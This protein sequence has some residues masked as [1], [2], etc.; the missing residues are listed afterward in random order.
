MKRAW[1]RPTPCLVVVPRDQPDLLDLLS[2]ELFADPEIEVVLDRREG[3][4]R[5]GRAGTRPDER[6]REDR[7]RSIDEGEILGLDGVVIAFRAEAREAA[8]P[9]LPPAEAGVPVAVPV[10]DEARARITNWL[11]ESQGVL[12]TVPTV[13]AR[14]RA[15]LKVARALERR[16]A[17]LATE[18]RT[19]RRE[20]QRL[21]ADRATLL[22][23][24]ERALPRPGGS[25]GEQETRIAVETWREATAEVTA[26]IAA[27]RERSEWL[28]GEIREAKHALG[29]P[30]PVRA[31]VCPRCASVIAGPG[32]DARWACVVCAWVGPTPVEPTPPP[33]AALPAV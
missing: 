20:H 26:L 10:L 30:T 32:A 14:Y 16:R 13:M 29:L 11:R 4:R 28:L 27:V 24:L 21:W 2:Q 15:L 5:R 12:E 33:P 8:R 9:M 31:A 25:E 23:I 22:R 1:G 7:R 18:L 17:R 6:R 3:E 19:L